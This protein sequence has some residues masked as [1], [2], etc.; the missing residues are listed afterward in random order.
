MAEDKID[1]EIEI[2]LLKNF[3]FFIIIFTTCIYFSRK[4]YPI[5]LEEESDVNCTRIGLTNTNISRGYVTQFA[6]H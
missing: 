5:L 3:N 6:F 2:Y 4:L 1:V